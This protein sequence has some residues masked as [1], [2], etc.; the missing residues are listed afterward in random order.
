MSISLFNSDD[1]VLLLK[2]G[3]PALFPT[4]TLPALAVIPEHANDLWSLKKRPRTKPFIL[5]ASSSAELFDF[6]LPEALKDAWEIGS[7]YWPGALT[8]V[9]P[10]KGSA[11]KFLNPFGSTIGM[12][13]PACD[14]A[15][16]LLKKS[17]P[18]A[19][20][21]AN[22]SGL[23]PLVSVMELS[24]TFPKVP[25]LGPLPW[26]KLSGLASTLIKWNG[27]GKWEMLRQG[28]VYL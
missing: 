7:A 3:S 18:L 28:S 15:I 27:E 23:E 26:P 25:L 22:L 24:K 4:D 14:L 16:D 20:T 5:M 19:T 11:V 13:V 9:L 2:E 17:G 1:L 21:S 10:A 12:R 8:L 6:V